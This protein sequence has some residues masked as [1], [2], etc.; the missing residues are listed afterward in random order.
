MAVWL[1]PIAVAL[2]ADQSSSTYARAESQDAAV[3]PGVIAA[4]YR[5]SAERII[6]S[7]MA[8]NDA[9]RKLEE[10]CLDIGHRLAG[11]KELF[12]ATQWAMAT[13]RRDGQ[14]NVRLQKVM[15]PR[16]VRGDEW[17][18]MMAPR[19]EPLAM[20]G[21]G[22]SIGTG[23]EPISAHV[24]VVNDKEELAR[25]GAEAKGKIV[26]FNVPMPEYDPKTGSGYGTAA[27]YRVNGAGWAS[28]RGAVAALVRSATARSLRSPHTGVMAYDRNNPKIPAAAISVEDAEMIASLYARKIPVTVRL[29]M[30]AGTDERESPSA[31]VLGELRGSALPD[32]IVVIGGHIDSWDV[33]QGA[34]DDG[35]GCVMAM[36]AINVLRKL[37]MIPRR[38]IRV[39]LW[40]SEE[41]GLQGG[42]AYASDNADELRR[43][44]AAIESDSG[45]FQPTGYG[46]ECSDP[47]RENKA[48]AQMRDILSLVTSIGPMEVRTGHSSSDISAMRDSGV[49]LMG[50]RV[51][52]SRYFDYHHSMADTIDKVD[53]EDLSKNVA[54]L[55]TV[56]Y[57]IA[58]M[59]ERIGE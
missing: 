31:N 39:V 14:E 43:H 4:Q 11:S 3:Q 20:L 37:N 5:E 41:M 29:M 9:Y 27:A 10:L 18:M 44:V 7:T 42:K 34:H 47:Q 23:D 26:V 57:I 12:K 2:G 54:L 52:G 22:G 38:T 15:V 45:V 48:A 24:V 35:G 58:D 40:T 36:E 51:E 19:I 59:P 53:P 50:Q 56:A 8:G 25:L 6:S 13:M 28:A 16:W 21:L 33:G 46:V 17:A 30:K 32:E 49:V 1:I 55:A